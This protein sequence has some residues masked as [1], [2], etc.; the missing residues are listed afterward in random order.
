MR[1][2]ILIGATAAA[3]AFGAVSANAIPLSPEAS[4]YALKDQ[5]QTSNVL[6]VIEGRSAYV[7]DNADVSQSAPTAQHFWEGRSFH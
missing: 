2:L 4:P 3:L 6:G 1:N 7:G 5:A